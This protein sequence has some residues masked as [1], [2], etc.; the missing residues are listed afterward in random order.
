MEQYDTDDPLEKLDFAVM[1]ARQALD[2]AA[3]AGESLN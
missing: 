3:I 2:R 1:V